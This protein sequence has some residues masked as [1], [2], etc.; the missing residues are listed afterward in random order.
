MLFW[1]FCSFLTKKI[2]Q[3]SCEEVFVPSNVLVC[4][5]VVVK[6]SKKEI[7]LK[8]VIVTK[9]KYSNFW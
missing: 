9:L 8:N 1:F 6:I 5:L 4:I 2:W 3:A 7:V